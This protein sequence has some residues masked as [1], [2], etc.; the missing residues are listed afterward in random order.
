[1]YVNAASAQALYATN[2]VNTANAAIA[3]ASQ[4]L[5]TGLRVNNSGDD[6]GGMAIANNFKTYLGSYNAALTNINDAVAMNQVADKALS[7]IYTTLSNMYTLAVSSYTADSSTASGA[8]TI[9]ANQLALASYQS[10][11]DTLASGATYKGKALLTTSAGLSVSVQ[12]GISSSDTLSLTYYSATGSKLGVSTSDITVSSSS[13]A[14]TAMTAIQ[15]AM[16]T[17]GKYQ[18]TVGAQ[19]NILNTQADLTK[20]FIT[21]NTK[22]YGDIM[23]ANMAE[24]SANL[25]TAQI[26]RD[27]STAMLAQANT[28]NKD[29]VKYLLQTYGG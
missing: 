16:Y 17:I 12:A 22:A 6:P 23:N 18:T 19:A 10:A 8:A 13:N 2:A 28:M 5:S 20:S 24:E 7:S 9:A 11:L 29:I 14:S 21:T 1:M 27:A 4:R 3:R 26:N 15:T 25:A